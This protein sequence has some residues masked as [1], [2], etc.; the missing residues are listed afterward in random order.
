LVNGG[1]HLL[2]HAS[3]G[4]MVTKVWRLETKKPT[5]RQCSL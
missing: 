5:H 4:I 1:V 2:A 3:K